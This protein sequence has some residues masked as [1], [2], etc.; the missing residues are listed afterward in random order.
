[1]FL[2]DATS[3]ENQRVG[4][5]KKRGFGQKKNRGKR[6]GKK[7]GK[8]GRVPGLSMKWGGGS[9]LQQRCVILHSEVR[10]IVFKGIQLGRLGGYKEG[11]GASTLVVLTSTFESQTL[12]HLG[13]G[14]CQNRR[15]PNGKEERKL[16]KGFQTERDSTPFYVCTSDKHACAE[17]TKQTREK[18]YRT[19]NASES[20]QEKKSSSSSHRTL[21]VST[22]KG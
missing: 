13:R 8:S 20:G 16:W 1:V 11:R 19:K 10:I 2:R 14:R 6:G 12:K 22:P 15:R 7:K 3:R 4:F 17:T 18:N 9:S 21:G 5:T